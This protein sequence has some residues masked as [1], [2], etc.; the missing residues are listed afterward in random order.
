MRSIRWLLLSACCLVLLAAVACGG[1]RT[2]T[3]PARPQCNDGKDNDGDGMIDFPDDLGCTSA[4]RRHRGQPAG[5]AVQRR[6]RQRR[7]RQDRLPERPGLL[8]RRNQDDETD[9]CPDGPNCP[10]CANGKDD[11]G[12]G[13]D[14]LPGRLRAARRPPTTTSTR[15]NPVACGAGVTIKPL[16]TE[17]RRR[18]ACSTGRATSNLTSTT[19]GGGAAPTD[20][21]ELRIHAPKVVVATTDDSGH[22][23]PTP[24]STSAA[25][26]A[27]A[28]AAEVACNDDV[29]TTDTQLDADAARCH[30]GHLLPRRRRPRAAHRRHR[31]TSTSSAS[32]A[33]AT[34]CTAPTSAAPA[35]C[36]ACR[37]AR[38]T[39]VCAKPMCSD[40]VDDDGDGKNDYPERSGLHVARPTTTRPTTARAAPNCPECAN[41]VDNDDDTQDRLSGGH[42]AAL[43]RRATTR[44]RARAREAV[45]RAHRPDDARRHDDRDRRLRRR[46]ARSTAAGK[47]LMYALDAAEADDVHARPSRTR[48]QLRT[49]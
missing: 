45:A 40:G 9:D 28:R 46:R 48:R 23:A 34:T 13:A 16:P 3:T 49:P 15:D 35:S 17:R 38:P 10:Q 25:R 39:K 19:C 37:W 30:A 4:E 33:K 11:D 44:G 29:S 24:S 14:R 8:S 42:D 32:P 12:N 1:D 22:H 18:R 27:R 7:R 20:V 36:A 21:Y 6:P 2:A 43:G 31:T 41:G 47:D 5:A 26:S